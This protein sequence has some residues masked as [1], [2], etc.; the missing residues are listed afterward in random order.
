MRWPCDGV[1]VPVTPAKLSLVVVVVV[2]PNDHTVVAL[3]S[4]AYLKM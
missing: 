4:T 3:C 1:W 2:F